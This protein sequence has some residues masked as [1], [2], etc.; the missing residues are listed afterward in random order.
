[1]FQSILFISGPEIVIIFLFILLFFGANKIPEIARAL[2]KGVREIKKATD[3]IKR[4][5]S[6]AGADLKKDL[7]DLKKD[8]E[9][10][11]DDLLG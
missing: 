10:T 4:E 8:V 5:M 7:N 3:E 2:G 11:K 6:D 1:M 9:N